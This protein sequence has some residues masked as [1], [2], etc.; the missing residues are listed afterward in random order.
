LKFYNFRII[1]SNLRYQ[2]APTVDQEIIL[3]LDNTSELGNEFD[4]ITTVSLPQVYEDERQ[5]CEVFRP[6]FQLNYIYDN[7]YV[8][9]T[10]YV[11]FRNNLFYFDPAGS[12]FTNIWYGN[13]QYFEFDFFRPNI[14]DQHIDYIAKSSYTYNWTYY[15]TYPFRNNPKKKLKY[16]QINNTSAQWVAEDGI[17]FRLRNIQFN[18][19]PLIS[20]ECIAP[21]GLQVGESVELSLS[22]NDIRI[23]EVFSLGN[24]ILGS[25][26]TVFNIYNLGY[27]GFTFNNGKKGKF[28]RII[29]TDAIEESRSKYYVREHKVLLSSD[30]IIINKTGFQQTPF[31]SQNKKLFLSS[32]T[33]NQVTTCVQ[34][35]SNNCYT[36]TTRKDINLQGLLDNQKRPVTELF[37]TV[38]HKGYSGYFNKPYFDNVGLKQGWEFNITEVQ[39]GWWDDTNRDSNSN[40]TTS[41]YE[42]TDISGNTKTFYYNNNLSVDDIIE[43]DFCEWNDYEQRERVISKYYHKIKYN[44]DNFQISPTPTSNENGFYYQPHHGTTIRVFSNYVETGSVTNVDQVPFYAFYSPSDEEF[45]WRDLYLYGFKDE[46]NRGV[47]YPYLN[48][49][50]YPFQNVIFRL[51]PEGKDSNNFL[52]GINEPVKPLIDGCE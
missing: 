52:R 22:Y 32:I 39:N 1:P 17:P 29:F 25:E 7:K 38:I 21:H 50:H 46:L 20:F 23:F 45:R 30:D 6:T 8:G 10:N 48:N 14:S 37:L 49:S 26:N 43:G 47:D 34:K 2:S 5:S 51:F 13:P 40:I 41:S 15:I 19:S 31:G 27:T 9:T 28:K 11:P 33:P 44:S 4:R 35:S 42:K 16:S 18:G 36:I 12:I 24:G 3:S